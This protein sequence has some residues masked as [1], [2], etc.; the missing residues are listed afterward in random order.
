LIAGKVSSPS[1]HLTENAVLGLGGPPSTLTLD[2]DI[3]KS[4]KL[5]LDKTLRQRTTRNGTISSAEENGATC[6]RTTSSGKNS[7]KSRGAHPPASHRL[8]PPP[9]MPSACQPFSGVT[10][11]VHL[12]SLRRHVRER[13][14][15]LLCRR[16]CAPKTISTTALDA[17]QART[18]I[19]WSSHASRLGI[20]PAALGL[21]HCYSRAAVHL[22]RIFD[23]RH[24][25]AR[26]RLSITIDRGATVRSNPQVTSSL[27]TASA[28]W[29]PRVR[30][31]D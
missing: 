20:D 5:R 31:T 21:A 2:G 12:T 22:K 7:K 23:D 15:R 18:V 25:F 3:T 29:P 6:G 17:A 10:P 4:K 30:D 11:E 26:S 13:L 24:A 1:A 19:R 8:R 9:P 16:A 28:A 14:N 27:P